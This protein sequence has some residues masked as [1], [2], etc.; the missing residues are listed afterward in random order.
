M[1]MHQSAKSLEGKVCGALMT[2]GFTP[3]VGCKAAY[4]T[5]HSY[6]SAVK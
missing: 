1:K 5:E 4:N 6:T 2:G 3:S